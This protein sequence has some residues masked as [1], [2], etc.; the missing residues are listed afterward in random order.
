MSPK[1]SRPM[2]TN[3]L[4]TSPP[5]KDSRMF[6][7]NWGE[8]V[9]EIQ[10]SPVGSTCSNTSDHGTK[11]N[12]K[13]SSN[14]VEDDP[15]NLN[16]RR[17]RPRLDAISSLIMEG[18]SSHSAIRCRVCNRVFP[19]EK[20]LQAHMR[21][22]TGDRPYICDYPECGRS[23]AQSGQ[24]KTHQRLHTGE[25]PFVCSETGCQNRFTHA[26]RH[27]AK[28]PSS[29]LQRDECSAENALSNNENQSEDVTKWLEKYYMDKTDRAT[30]K[31]RDRKLKREFDNQETE[32]AV[33]QAK[34]A[35]LDQ[36]YF[37]EPQNQT[38]ID[39]VTEPAKENDD[40]YMGA[41]ALIELGAICT[42]TTD[43][44]EIEENYDIAGPLDL[45]CSSF[46]M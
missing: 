46:T 8:G 7:W 22:H 18:T 29:P 12:L 30:T 16:L 39:I 1:K 40:K 2:F 23:F 27:C 3:N 25:K 4:V 13:D 37:D 24:L 45:S 26:N 20:S 9:S 42:V 43:G 33:C 11:N 28:H 44:V 38:L 32:D 34:A 6:P 36:A 31:L 17:G 41:L 5:I 35:C 10:L 19:R 21:T 14:N 15:N